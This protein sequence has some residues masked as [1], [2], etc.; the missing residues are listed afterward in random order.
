MKKT[1]LALAITGLF[2]T[3]AQAAN[4]YDADG[5]SADV[6]GRM[7][8]EVRENGSDTDG[9]GTA[10]MGFDAKSAIT[11]DISAI[12]KGEWQIASENSTADDEEFDTRH[13]YVGFESAAYGKLI[14]GQTD[15]AF[16]QAIAATDMY[17][18]FGYGAFDNGDASVDMGRQEGQIIYSGEF[19][20]VYVGASYQFQ[21][22]ANH[23]D[24]TYALTLGYSMADFAVYGGALIQEFDNAENKTSYALSASYTM[25]DLYLAAAYAGSEQDLVADYQGYDFFASYAIDA[26]KVYGGYTFQE[27][28]AGAT[29]TDHYEAITMGA[30]YSLNA[31]MLAWI[32]YKA[33]LISGNDDVLNIAV[34]YNF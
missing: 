25:D 30:S 1:I 28:E 15:S 4:V 6:Y 32:E 21:D 5:V 11:S 16:Y 27:K 12:A 24:D 9:V 20:G 34:Q 8:F 3:T 23:I 13:L 33:D 26:A 29:T 31:N 7:Q 22:A 10:R 18:K 19:A 17:N 2:A 14:F